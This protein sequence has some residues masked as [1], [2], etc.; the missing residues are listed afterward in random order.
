MN[1]LNCGLSYSDDDHVQGRQS[2]GVATPP[3]PEFWK[4][5]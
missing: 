3:P 1:E 4:G 2:G 5:D